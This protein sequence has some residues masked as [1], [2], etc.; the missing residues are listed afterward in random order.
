MSSVNVW[1]FYPNLVGYGRIILAILSFEAMTY[2][3]IRAAF[4]YA[5]SVGL[6]AV[7]GILARKFDQCASDF[8]PRCC[9]LIPFK[10]MFMS[11]HE[12]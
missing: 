1:S 7:D 5:L 8:I 6:D 11:L 10:I 9:T 2:A 4:F 3:P 12:S